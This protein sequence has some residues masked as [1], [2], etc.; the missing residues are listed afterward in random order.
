MLVDAFTTTVAV[1]AVCDEIRKL[2]CCVAPASMAL[3]L[4]GDEPAAPYT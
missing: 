3:E 2:Y 4:T 1:L